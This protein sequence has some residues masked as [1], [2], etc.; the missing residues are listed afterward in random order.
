MIKFIPITAKLKETNATY[1]QKQAE[2]KTIQQK[3]EALAEQ[4]L[5]LE[6]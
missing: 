6:A 1:T 4:I 2:L 5:E 3:W